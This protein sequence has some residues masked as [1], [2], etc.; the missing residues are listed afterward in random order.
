MIVRRIAA[1]FLLF[2]ITLAVV[3]C[4]AAAPA[5]VASHECCAFAVMMA[6]PD[7]CRSITPHPAVIPT[8]DFNLDASI[9]SPASSIWNI[10]PEAPWNHRIPARSP[11]PNRLPATILRT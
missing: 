8:R 11:R 1:L 10:E 3:P 6:P 2:A 5:K 7:C 4:F 9:E